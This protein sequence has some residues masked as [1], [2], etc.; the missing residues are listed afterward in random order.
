MSKVTIL[1]T[2]WT[3]TISS[4]W[5]C[6]IYLFTQPDQP[7][8]SINIVNIARPFTFFMENRNKNRKRIFCGK[9]YEIDDWQFSWWPTKY[10][11]IINIH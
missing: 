5:R 4:A 9:Y 7:W 3:L 2:R 10:I 11:L 1:G 6:I 8:A